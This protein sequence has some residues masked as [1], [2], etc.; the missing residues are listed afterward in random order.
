MPRRRGDET[1]I[2]PHDSVVQ[3]PVLLCFTE[4][5]V[6]EVDGMVGEQAV[7]DGDV[8]DPQRHSRLLHSKAVVMLA[9]YQDRSCKFCTEELGR[10]TCNFCKECRALYRV[11]TSSE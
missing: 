6:E 9:P 5:R 10:I 11:E 2:P 8:L 7:Q 4:R 3:L 1:H